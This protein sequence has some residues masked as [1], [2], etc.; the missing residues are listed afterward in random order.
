MA[1]SCA[2]DIEFCHV[3][4]E[5]IRAHADAKAIVLTCT[6]T[7]FSAGVDLRRVHDG[8]VSYIAE[9]LPALDEPF[10]ALFEAP[11]PVVAAINGHA[12]AGGCL[13][14]AACDLRLMSGGAIGVTEML[15]G[16]PFPLAGLEIMRYAF[17]GVTGRSVLT[18]EKLDAAA[19]RACGLIDELVDPDELM[20]RALSSVPR[21][22]PRSLRR[23]TP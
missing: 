21:H 15:V 11:R 12:L 17:G 3:I 8:G 6:G 20:P 23:P 14:A 19:A 22:S 4:T 18:A 2:L 7:V 13:L 1:K 9:F 16:L 10:L 5:T